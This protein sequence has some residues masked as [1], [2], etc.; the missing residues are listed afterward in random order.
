[1]AKNWREWR[2]LNIPFSIRR[3]YKYV[4]AIREG[5]PEDTEDMSDREID[6]I[7]TE[8]LQRLDAEK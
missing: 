2:R 1:M 7:F 6:T 5:F 8:E 3:V 4:S